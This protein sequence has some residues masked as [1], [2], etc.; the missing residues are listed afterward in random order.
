MGSRH[1]LG[2]NWGQ[3]L[4]IFL[5][6]DVTPLMQAKQELEAETAE[7]RR[8]EVK[9]AKYIHHLE[10]LGMVELEESGRATDDRGQTTDEE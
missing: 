2:M 5:F 10:E 4:D 3:V 7:R 6:K 1:Y 8:V 9:L